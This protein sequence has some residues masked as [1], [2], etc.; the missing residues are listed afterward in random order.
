MRVV[1]AKELRPS[2][3]LREQL[4]VIIHV[5]LGR[6]GLRRDSYAGELLC[7]GDVVGARTS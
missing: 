5:S 6:L 7:W 4:F 2:N 3:Q 1:T